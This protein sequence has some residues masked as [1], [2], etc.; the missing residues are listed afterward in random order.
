MTETK[1]DKE[2]VLSVSQLTEQLKS[3]LYDQFNDVWVGGEISNLSRAQSGHVY[4]T[5]GDNY[6]QLRGL[7]WRSTALELDFELADGLEVICR[8][9][10]DVYP[11]RGTYQLIIQHIEPLGLGALQLAFRQLHAKLAAEG[12]FNA[13]NKM[14][15]P[16]FP[17][18]IAIVTSPTGAAIN[19]FLQVVTRRWPNLNFLVIPTRVQGT[20]AAREIARGIEIAGRLQPPPDVLVVTRGGGSIEDL[21]SFNDEQVVRAIFAC[22]IPTISAVGHEID[23]TL[24]DLAADVRA[25]TPSQAGELVVQEK[26][27]YQRMLLE[28]SN[29]IN[30]AAKSNL[31]IAR[32][33]LQAVRQRQVM[34][35]PSLITENATRQ[36]ENLRGRLQ[37][38]LRTTTMIARQRLV[39]LENRR[40]LRRPE[41]IPHT[42]ARRVDELDIRL[43]NCFERNLEQARASFH[44]LSARLEAI[45]PL[46]VLS[47]GYS[48][49]ST[50]DGIAISDVESAEVGQTIVTRLA[51]GTLKSIISE[52][53]PEQANANNSK[54]LEK[55]VVD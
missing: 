8:G 53:S 54:N 49:T 41:D 48:V 29:R 19:D 26:K 14:P 33:R 25:L 50:I 38:T 16:A 52:T 6:S 12:L 2:K 55:P 39:A 43:K 3:V 22:P 46:N 42:F 5:L 30:V 37:T 47:R 18:R 45:S 10:I 7:I 4:L 15:L 36:I 32:D 40:A 1:I 34:R 9:E 28:I 51:H 13:A 27:V 44:G 23:V 31:A 17:Q 11:P 24:S 20:D 35:R 21:W